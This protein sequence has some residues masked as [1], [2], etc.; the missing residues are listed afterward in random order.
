MEELA[1]AKPDLILNLSASPFHVAKLSVRQKLLKDVTRKTKAP[2]LYCNLVGKRRVGFDGW[3]G[4]RW[5]GNLFQTGKS[6]EEDFFVYDTENP[7]LKPAPP[8][9]K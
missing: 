7:A 4:F 8:L 1:R 6:F 5:G 3:H 9:E 2:V